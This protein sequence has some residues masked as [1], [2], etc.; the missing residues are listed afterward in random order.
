[1]SLVGSDLIQILTHIQWLKQNVL[2]HDHSWLKSLSWTTKRSISNKPLSFKM[3]F[4]TVEQ[5]LTCPY[6]MFISV[7]SNSKQ[8]WILLDSTCFYLVAPNELN[9]SICKFW[10]FIN[11][12]IDSLLLLYHV[13][14]SY[15][16]VSVSQCV[17][18]HVRSTKAFKNVGTLITI[19]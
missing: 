3:Y 16:P 19:K 4:W 17:L 7:A 14:H 8:C 13:A 5:N 15:A 18:Q 2:H 12:L 11:P 10:S 1:M 6:V 9:I